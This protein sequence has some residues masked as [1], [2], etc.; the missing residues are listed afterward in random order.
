MDKFEKLVKAIMKE[1]EEDGEP[2]TREEA[3]EMAKMEMG[4]NANRR[5]ETADEPKKERKPKERKI[6]EEK[7]YLLQN[8]KV[9]L[10]GMGADVVNV[11]TE[12]EISFIYGENDYTIK[13]TKHRPKK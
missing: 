11:K 1:A 4:A 7:K 3:E 6:D 13:L 12:T 5:Y 8:V 10:D 9:L 2:V